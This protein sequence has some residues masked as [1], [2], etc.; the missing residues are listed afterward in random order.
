M[1]T[2]YREALIILISWIL[3]HGAYQLYLFLASFLVSLVSFFTY[4]CCAKREQ[5]FY[6]F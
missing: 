1:N 4:E 6:V 5:I 2:M 3:K